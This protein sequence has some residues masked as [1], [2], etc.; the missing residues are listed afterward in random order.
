MSKH[1]PNVSVDLI[2]SARRS[3]GVLSRLSKEE[4]TC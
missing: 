1:F 4:L 2:E 3:D